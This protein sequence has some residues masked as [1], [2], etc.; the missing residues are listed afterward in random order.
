M[1]SERD[2]EHAVELQPTHGNPND[3]IF[4]ARDEQRVFAIAC[5]LLRSNPGL[6]WHS[7]IEVLTWAEFA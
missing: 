2:E 5:L 7:P 4:E 3:G 6:P 1:S